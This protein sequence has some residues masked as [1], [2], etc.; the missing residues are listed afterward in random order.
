MKANRN[1]KDSVFVN[2]FS[3]R[4]NLLEL[5]AAISGEEMPPDAVLDINTLDD[6]LYMDQLN[7]ISFTLAEK[8]IVL[9]EAQTTVNPNMPLR[10]LEY[11]GRLYEKIIPRE[12]VYGHARVELPRPDFYILYNGAEDAPDRMQLRLSDLFAPAPANEMLELTA[13]MFNVNP[14][15][16]EDILAKSE[17]LIGYSVL[18]SMVRTNTAVETMPL[19]VAIKKAVE[20]CIQNDY[21][22]DYLTKHGSEVSNMLIY[23]YDR[24]MDIKVNREEAREETTEDI[25]RKMK[26]KG[27]SCTDIADITGLTAEAI[28]QL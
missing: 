7:D 23:E 10:L 26:A 17:A 27:L 21:I 4:E 9:I 20:Y 14:G 15:H 12:K 2:L 19:A 24:E 18:V 25:A 8:Q 6:A 13:T 3:E 5:K 11:I 28:A 16:N 22:A 1:F